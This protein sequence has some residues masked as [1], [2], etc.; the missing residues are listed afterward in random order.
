FLAITPQQ[1]KAV[2]AHDH[3]VGAG[4]MAVSLFI[5]AN[6][7]LRD[8]GGKMRLWQL[9]HGVDATGAALLPAIE[10]EVGGVGDEVRAPFAALVELALA[11]E[12]VL[13]AGEAIAE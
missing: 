8:V 9:Q 6:R 12:E 10:L 5:R 1:R 11:G 13:L 2:A 3:Q 7:E 4:P